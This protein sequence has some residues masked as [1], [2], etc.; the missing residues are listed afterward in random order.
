MFLTV[1]NTERERDYYG[2]WRRGG[3]GRR[4]SVV[5]SSKEQGNLLLS[6]KLLSLQA[7]NGR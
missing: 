4:I 1:E 2:Y 7:N 6:N 3:R 5:E